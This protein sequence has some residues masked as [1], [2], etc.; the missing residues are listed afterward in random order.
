MI[1]LLGFL[2]H[3]QVLL[4][5]VLRGPGRA[6]DALQLLVAV[7]TAPIGAGHFHQLEVLELARAR[8]VRAAAQVLELAF[9]IERHVFA[10]R[11][12]GNDLRLVGLAETLEVGHGLVARQHAA[13]DLLVLLRELDHLRL[14]GRQILRREGPLVGEV[15]VEAVLDDRADRHL[16]L[17]EQLLHRIGQQV[18]RRVADHVQAVGVLLRHDGQRRVGLDQVAGVHQVHCVA[19]PQ[20]T[21]Q[22]RLGQARADGRGDLGH[23]HRAGVLAF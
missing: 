10:L 14:D 7:V 19:L 16:R 2:E 3:V 23:R 20:A 21:P 5:L 8:H 15:V 18:R 17:G 9:A 13:L 1:A 22:R 11:D 12:A 6:V 4:Q